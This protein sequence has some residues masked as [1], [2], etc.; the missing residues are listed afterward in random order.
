[1][2]RNHFV[3]HAPYVR[4]AHKTEWVPEKKSRNRP[5][6]KSGLRPEPAAR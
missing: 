2:Q 3:M 4:I 1:M 5:A 6:R